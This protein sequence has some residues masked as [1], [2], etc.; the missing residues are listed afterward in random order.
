MQGLISKFIL[1]LFVAVLTCVGFFMDHF[2]YNWKLKN[3]NT[4]SQ[5]YSYQIVKEGLQQCHN[6]TQY[7]DKT[8]SSLSKSKNLNK[9]SLMY[10]S[11]ANGRTW[12]YCQ[13]LNA[14]RSLAFNWPEF[15]SKDQNKTVLILNDAKELLAKNT[16]SV[17]SEYVEKSPLVRAANKN[18]TNFVLPFYLNS[19]NE[20]RRGSFQ[21]VIGTNL[22]LFVE[23][24]ASLD[25]WLTY[26]FTWFMTLLSLALAIF[27]L[28]NKR[29]VQKESNPT[30]KSSRKYG[31]A[32]LVILL[33]IALT[34]P[35]DLQARI[36]SSATI[37]SIE[38]LSGYVFTNCSNSILPVLFQ[39]DRI[40]SRPGCYLNLME[41]TRIRGY[42][43]LNKR[44]RV[45]MD[46]P[47]FIEL[48]AAFFSNTN[49][50]FK[51]SSSLDQDL[52]KSLQ[53]V[54][55]GPTNQSRSFTLSYI[56]SQGSLP[57]IFPLQD[58][59]LLKSNRSVHLKVEW[60][61]DIA[62]LSKY[63]LFVWEKGSFP[64]AP[65][66]VTDKN[67]H[68]IEFMQ[69]GIYQI[70]VTSLDKSKAS[71]ILAVDIKK[72]EGPTDIAQQLEEY[73]VQIIAPPPNSVYTSTKLPKSISFKLKKEERKITQGFPQP[74]VRFLVLEEVET[75]IRKRIPFGNQNAKDVNI[76]SYG[77]WHLW[78][79][80]QKQVR[81]SSIRKIS[82]SKHKP[83][84]HLLLN[85]SGD[86]YVHY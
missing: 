43:K 47:V 80:N 57:W 20:L 9:K 1:F 36:D 19:H 46:G 59:T 86:H 66:V 37:G 53:E 81:I 26:R 72:V 74:E 2:F 79:E 12:I 17:S 32:N 52:I 44:E 61:K 25:Y 30:P 29:Q 83:D 28:W 69:A 71:S 24:D 16:F 82:L 3:L 68:V 11:Q 4:L 64:K 7:A 55:N 76:E 40:T 78:F 38:V 5:S 13:G 14:G 10:F 15:A 70:Q 67:W 33:L 39:G 6:S 51:I 21:Q 77:T 50:S 22:K 41:K 85:L 63:E 42:G 49:Q 31:Y 18:I 60:K 34:T 84:F 75:Q 65:L 58:M 56:K 27:F 45:T 23:M 48:D 54:L 73:P 8:P 62:D 35:K